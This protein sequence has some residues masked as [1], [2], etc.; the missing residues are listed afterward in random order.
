MQVDPLLLEEYTAGV[1]RAVDAYRRKMHGPYGAEAY[2]IQTREIAK[3]KRY[4]ARKKAER[5]REG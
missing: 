2:A 1:R 4:K 3:V 5:D